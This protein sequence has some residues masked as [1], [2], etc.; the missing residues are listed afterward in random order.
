MRGGNW[1]DRLAAVAHMG[2]RARVVEHRV[3]SPRWP[4]PPLRIAVLSDVHAGAPWTPLAAVERLAR[5]VTDLRPDLILLP[6][7]FVAEPRMPGRP[8]APVAVMRALEPLRAPLGVFAVMGNHD[9][10]DFPVSRATGFAENPVRDALEAS[11]FTHLRNRAV[12]VPHGAG[13]WLAGIDSQSAR[14]KLRLPGFDRLDLAFA[15]VP[16]GVPSILLAHEPDIFAEG[17]PALLQVSGHT[18]GG[19]ANLLGWRPL[20]PSAYGGRYAWGH[21]AEGDRHLIVSGGIGYTGV[22]LRLLQ[23]PEITLVTLTGAA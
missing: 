14:K 20:T 2:A 6:G 16:D 12:R 17:T 22:P 18:H 15:G 4:L 7:D 5:E 8:A 19:Q 3:V 9:W 1:R 13:F 21:V 10:W 23:P 11:P